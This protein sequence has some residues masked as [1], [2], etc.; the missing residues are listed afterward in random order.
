M[1]TDSFA[2]EVR[3]PIDVESLGKYLEQKRPDIFSTPLTL[4]QFGH[5][6]SNP[7]YLVIDA[8]KRKY[9]LR[10][11]PPGELLSPSS[12]R[13]DREYYIMQA[14]ARTEVP[15]P[16]TYLLCEDSSL[17]GTPFYIMQFMEGRIFHSPQFS[18]DTKPD[19]RTALWKAAL[20]TLATIHSLDVKKLN[21]PPNIF[22][23][24]GGS[25][26][27][28]QMRTLT[29]ISEA[30]AK[31]SDIQAIPHFKETVD[32]LN[33]HMPGN[34][35]VCIVHGDYKIDNL[36]YHPTENRIIGLLDFELCT[37]GH[38]LA[39]VGN[40]L[41]PFDVAQLGIQ[42]GGMLEVHPGENG[43][44][45]LSQALA[46]YASQG[47]YD[48]RSDWKFGM[49]YTHL[50]LAVILQGVAAR[51]KRGQAS[52]AQAGEFG[53][54]YPTFGNLAYNATKELQVKL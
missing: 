9:V 40:L 20:Q 31:G 39:D 47:V 15:V 54:L 7:S 6:Q 51:S 8:H 27:P 22:N 24:N 4:K 50:R 10:K 30:Q 46:Y 49:A 21:L 44:L 53:K 5:G 33:A 41:Q 28:R 18:P 25:H 37:I 3:H 29:K 2:G 48:P 52:S 23:V 32:W 19:D 38:P 35:P 34:T 45:T 14:L 11:K 1:S 43:A 26:F 42:L 12:H 16:K 36:V 17:I 13:I